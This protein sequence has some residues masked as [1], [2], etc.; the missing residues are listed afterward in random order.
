MRQK[1]LCFF[2]LF[3]QACGANAAVGKSVDHSPRERAGTAP[4][5]QG[6]RVAQPLS[7]ESTATETPRPDAGTTE[8]AQADAGPPLYVEVPIEDPSGTALARFYEALERARTGAGQARL[9]FYGASHVASDLFTNG[10]RQRLQAEFGEGGAGFLF[11]A[12]PW[13]WYRHSGIKLV[14][15]LGWQTLRVRAAR[16]REG[17]YGFAGVA[18]E[19]R[20]D[21]QARGVIS[22]RSNGELSGKSSR[23]ELFYLK[24]PDGGR[25]R[26]F[27]D[28]ERVGSISTASS[29]H[30]AGY[31]LFEVPDGHHRFE[32]RAIGNGPIRI[33][34]VAIER[35]TPGVVLD[36]VGI[37]GARASFH[38]LW[39]DALYREQLA[40]RR[41]DLV[42]LAYGTNEASDD[43]LTIPFY[44]KG[45]REVMDRIKETIPAASCLLIGPSDLPRKL[46]YPED[47]E[48]GVRSAGEQAADQES[49]PDA[50]I[51]NEAAP[52]AGV[53]AFAPAGQPAWPDA[54]WYAERGYEPRPIT[55]E[56]I[57]V[58]RGVA[59]DYSCGFFDL[60]RFMGGEMSMVRWAAASPPL[61]SP[62]HIH[63]T[64]AGYRLLGEVLHRALLAGYRSGEGRSPEPAP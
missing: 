56:I 59:R 43:D 38:A 30:E 25:M 9:L 22:T 10:I 63:Y 18:L 58:Q 51:E 48:Q 7:P 62:D 6:E 32:V 24:Q 8:P 31:Q 29:R 21:R 33:F 15:S 1:A 64:L 41:P 52:D 27:I 3:F 55:S 14:R 35:D 19:S 2:I 40:R 17:L 34:G 5:P 23:F 28:G 37:P 49:M 50:A 16:P 54:E 61:G 36:T 45:L 12:K 13:R 53:N 11:P 57:A 20:A 39:N 60:V 47:E 4:Q 42:V 44:E 46:Q 26:V